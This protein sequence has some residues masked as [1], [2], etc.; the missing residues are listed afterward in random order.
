MCRQ[1]T[2]LEGASNPEGLDLCGTMKILNRGIFLC[3]DETSGVERVAQ[4]FS[5]ETLE[6]CLFIIGEPLV[7]Q[8][9]HVILVDM[10]Y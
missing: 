3:P 5:N 4:K 8:G 2:Y 9:R 7:A 6:H 1:N 10:Q